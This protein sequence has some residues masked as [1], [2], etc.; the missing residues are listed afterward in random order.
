MCV[1]EHKLLWMKLCICR[2]RYPFFR[3]SYVFLLSRRLVNQSEVVSNG[4]ARGRRYQDDFRRGGLFVC[5]WP[6]V[7]YWMR[8]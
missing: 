8:M 6:N 1:T 5:L 2:I 3:D 4:K 7:L